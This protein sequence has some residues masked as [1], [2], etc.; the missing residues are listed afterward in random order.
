MHFHESDEKQKEPVRVRRRTFCPARKEN[1]SLEFPERRKETF[2]IP[3]AFCRCKVFEFKS[4]RRKVMAKKHSRRMQTFSLFARAEK[5][6][7]V[8]I[9][10][11][12]C[13]TVWYSTGFLSM[14]RIRT[15]V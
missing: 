11:T 9:A 10:R 4:K 8:G 2:R 6:L 3:R 1:Q 12:G 13:G 5:Q 15:C 14:Q 7:T